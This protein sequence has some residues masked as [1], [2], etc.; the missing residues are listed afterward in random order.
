MLQFI[1]SLFLMNK[2][3]LTITKQ[4]KPLAAVD[5]TSGNW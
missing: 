1:S 2:M 4:Y 5:Y 3:M